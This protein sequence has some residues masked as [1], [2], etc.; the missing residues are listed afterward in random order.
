MVPRSPV[1]E[2]SNV[3]GK[4]VGFHNG[5][6]SINYGLLWGI[7]AYCLGLLGFLFGFCKGCLTTKAVQTPRGTT[8]LKVQVGCCWGPEHGCRLRGS[9]KPLPFWWQSLSYHHPK[10]GAHRLGSLRC[11]GAHRSKL[12]CV[13]PVPCSTLRCSVSKE[14]KGAVGSQGRLHG[15][16]YLDPKSM[17]K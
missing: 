1:P 13:I 3:P 12:A 2:P 5:L 16:T 6:L 10:G 11:L 14:R 7:V 4:P 17:L 8:L 15:E 9:T